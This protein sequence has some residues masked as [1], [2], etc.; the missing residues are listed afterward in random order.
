L[1][2]FVDTTQLLTSIEDGINFPVLRYADVLLIYAEA[3][4]EDQGAP[5]DAAYAAINQ[6]RERAHVPDLPTGLSQDDFRQA[7]YQERRLEF[8]QEGQ[9]WFDLARTGRIVSAIS[10]I[11]AKKAVSDRNA[12]FPIPQAEINVNPNV[13]QN[14]GWQ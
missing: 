1:R 12:L 4:N 13:T 11:P 2:K 9:R 6:V 7:V 3:V 5:T 8:V 10:K 14:P